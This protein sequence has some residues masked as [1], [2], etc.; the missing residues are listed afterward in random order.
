MNLHINLKR[1]I[2]KSEPLLVMM[3]CMVLFIMSLG[4]VAT[5]DLLEQIAMADNY[6]ANGVLHAEPG[7]DFIHGHSVYFPGVS[8]LAISL[9]FLGVNYYLVEV[10]LFLGLLAL[11]SFMYLLTKYAEYFSKYRYSSKSFFSLIISYFLLGIPVYLEYALEFK[12]DTIALF[13]GYVGLSLSFFQNFNWG[14][15]ILG[16]LMIGVAIVFK[17]Q[18]IAFQIG[19]LFSSIFVSNK[20]FRFSVILSSIF[21]F[22]VFLFLIKDSRIR[23]WTIEV[24]ADD[25]LLEIG[26]IFLDIFKLI[27]STVLIVIPLI[28]LR[29][30][31]KALVINVPRLFLN[32]FNSIKYNPWYVSTFFVVAAAFLSSFKVGGNVGNTQVALAVLFPIVGLIIHHLVEW[33]IILFAWFSL[34]FFVN[35]KLPQHITEYNSSIELRSYVQRLSIGDSCKIL[36]GSNVYFASRQM[37]REGI[38]L[39]NY[40]SQ[41]IIAN[42]NSHPNLEIGLRK[43]KYDYIIVENFQDNLDR[44]KACSDY[45]ILFFNTLGIVAK[46]KEL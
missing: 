37:L 26:R 44:L 32:L 34:F 46:S 11:L 45:E 30:R 35:H 8:L 28:L 9:Q 1:Y 15:Y 29:R 4:K 24:L 7:S 12:P 31:A 3:F 20:K 17:Q 18:F 39:E 36:T 16:I 22:C 19:V 2:I 33:K 42:S 6:R 43:K 40:W 21:A 25:G 14:K 13:L 5:W 27:I 41:S 38:V 23:F 10:M